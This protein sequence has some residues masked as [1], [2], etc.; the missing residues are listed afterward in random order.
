MQE[1]TLTRLATGC[2]HYATFQSHNQK[3]LQ[4]SHGIFVTHFTRYDQRAFRCRWRLLRST[5]GGSS[6]ELLYESGLLGGNKPPCIEEG[7]DGDLLALCENVSY[8]E[9]PRSQVLPDR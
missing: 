2:S 6:F 5:D 4:T 3:V 9:E 8:P 7:E 1:I